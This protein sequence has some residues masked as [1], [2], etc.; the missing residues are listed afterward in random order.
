MC[1]HGNIRL[2]QI[3]DRQIPIDNCISSIV[4]ALNDGGVS[5]AMSCCGHGAREGFIMLADG[6]LL[7]VLPQEAFKAQGF[8]KTAEYFDAIKK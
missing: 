6:R 8:Q 7:A 3:G 2:L 4:K 5:T 1:A